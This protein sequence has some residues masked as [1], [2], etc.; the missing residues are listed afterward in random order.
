MLSILKTPI[1]YVQIK[2]NSFALRCAN[3]G[4][5]IVL[6]APTPFST[7]R[8]LIGEFSVAED[9]LKKAF[10]H[11]PKSLVSPIVVMHPL[12]MVDE[13]LSEVE[14]KVLREIAMTVGARDV[15]LWIGKE[16]TDQEL[17]NI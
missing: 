11:F 4:E 5:S 10:S 1:Y 12:E 6:N 3:T 17:L 7:K 8:L 15:K 9:L 13:K 16:L 2:K 14:K